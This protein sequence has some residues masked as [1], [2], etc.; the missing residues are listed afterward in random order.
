MTGNPSTADPVATLAELVAERITA[1]GPSVARVALTRQEAARAI[2]VSVDH[3]ERHVLAE[4]RVIRSGRLVLVPVAELER[5]ARDQAA[6]ALA[7]HR[8][9]STMGTNRSKRPRT[10]E[11]AGGMAQE[12]EPPM[13]HHRNASLS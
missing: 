4:L 8:A 1:R 3:F 6:F 11:T 10:A 13:Q 5:W 12:S 2:G 7:E 9:A